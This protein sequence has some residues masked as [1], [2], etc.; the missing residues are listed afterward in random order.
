MSSVWYVGKY[1]KRQLSVQDWAALGAVVT[2]GT[3]WNIDNG[4]SISENS[5]TN[6]QLTILSTLDG[7]KTGQADGPRIPANAESDFGGGASPY[8]AYFDKMVETFNS[9]MSTK[10][11][12]AQSF[13]DAEVFKKEVVITSNNMWAITSTGIASANVTNECNRKVGISAFGIRLV[14]ANSYTS[15]SPNAY[16]ADPT[17]SCTFKAA[18]NYGGNVIGAT[19]GGKQTAT[20]EPGGFLISDVIPIQVTKGDILK[21]RTFVASGTS[22]WNFIGLA[23][24]QVPGGHYQAATGDVAGTKGTATATATFAGNGMA[25]VAIIGTPTD[26]TVLPKGFLI[27]GQSISFGASDGIWQSSVTGHV[28]EAP[29][30]SGGGFLMRALEGEGGV[31]QGALG[32]N[33]FRDYNLPYGHFR[34]QSMAR[35]ARIAIVGE[36]INDLALPRTLAQAQGDVVTVAK[37]N[38][39]LGVQRNLAW[40]TVPYTSST[41]NWATVANQSIRGTSQLETDRVAYNTWVRDGMPISKIDGSPLASFTSV[42]LRCGDK[43]HPFYGWFEVADHVESARNSGKWKA[44]ERVIT[45]ASISATNTNLGSPAQAN[46]TIADIGKEV[47]LEGAGS[48]TSPYVNSPYVGFITNV[49]GPTAATMYKRSAGTSTTAVSGAK[50]II[51]PWCNDGV[52]PSSNANAYIAAQIKPRILELAS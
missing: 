5:F 37:R 21:V 24:T 25:P 45:D 27:Q 19:F 29:V 20:L 26:T 41:D 30:W 34:R 1:G 46:F 32:G 52:H 28:A 39:Y 51:G 2:E 44:A 38:K 16:D 18:I 47:I 31:L 35:F 49:A 12:M 40:T 10:D 36:P 48:E 14:Y 7:F 8:S 4:W 42:A 43:G 13:S 11:G 15:P 6:R 22:P 17:T 3:E 33:N 9:F 50:A 23:S